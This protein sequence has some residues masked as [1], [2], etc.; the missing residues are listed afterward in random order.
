MFR[1]GHLGLENLLG[2][3]SPEKTDC[4]TLNSHWLP[5]ALHLEGGLFEMFS[6]HVDISAGAVLVQ[7]LSRLTY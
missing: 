5:L 7:V 2:D 1:A 6:I 4:P 3:L